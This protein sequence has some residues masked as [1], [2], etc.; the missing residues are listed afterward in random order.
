MPDDGGETTDTDERARTRT[1][2]REEINVE[3][4]EEQELLCPVCD[5]WYEEE[6]I[7]PVG[8]GV[9]EDETG[10]HYRAYFE[11]DQLCESCA[12]SL[13]GY[14]GP[15]GAFDYLAAEWEAIDYRDLLSGAL[16]VATVLGSAA[17]L[18]HGIGW[19][20]VQLPS[21]GAIADSSVTASDPTV[22][23]PIADAVSIV[24]EVMPLMVLLVILIATAS[25]IGPGRI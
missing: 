1:V 24:A 21:S 12:E 6:E 17:A 11:E 22:V 25:A 13:F 15:A 16:S 14:D 5:Q 18:L 23:G 3:T 7:V 4:V 19:L 20:L 10:A 2:E 9:D 8:L